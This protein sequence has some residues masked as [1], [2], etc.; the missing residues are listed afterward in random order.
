MPHP[1]RASNNLQDKFKKPSLSL[2]LDKQ[3]IKTGERSHIQN[4]E[5]SHILGAPA[6]IG[7]LSEPIQKRAHHLE[8]Q[9]ECWIHQ[10]RQAHS[11]LHVTSQR[12]V[13]GAE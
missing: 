12:M 11:H 13:I 3:S 10:P 6:D 2:R 9:S 1:S 8:L 4:G 5:K 7:R